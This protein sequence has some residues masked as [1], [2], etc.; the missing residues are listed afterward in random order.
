[1][2]PF[3]IHIVK[4]EQTLNGA[5]AQVECMQDQVVPKLMAA[6]SH[7]LR[8]CHEMKH[9]VLNAEMKLRASLKRK[10]SRGLHYRSD[11]P[12]RDDN[13]LCYITVQKGD[14]GS[15]TLSKVD[16][17]DEWKG[18]LAPNYTK[19]YGWRF[20]GETEAKGLPPEKKN[21]GS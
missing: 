15:M 1:M 2:A 5:L 4:T 13:F 16:I 10:E 21:T 17:K 12:Y 20:P 19:R 8:L 3:W 9:K 6:S 18:D 11:Y 7:D 14:N